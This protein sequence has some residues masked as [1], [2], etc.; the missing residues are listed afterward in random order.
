MRYE[1]LP[2]SSTYVGHC[3]QAFVV[4]ANIRVVHNESEDFGRDLVD[5]GKPVLQRPNEAEDLE[6]VPLETIDLE[7]DTSQ[8]PFTRWFCSL[9]Q[10]RPCRG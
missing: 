8:R 2:P 1:D 6:S 7:Q 4:V 10:P 9:D 3:D 5:W